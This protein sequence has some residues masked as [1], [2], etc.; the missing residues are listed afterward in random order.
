MLT[1]GF[2]NSLVSFIGMGFNTILVIGSIFLLRHWF[3]FRV[4]IMFCC[5]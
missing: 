2:W 5:C 3:H 1:W 4:L